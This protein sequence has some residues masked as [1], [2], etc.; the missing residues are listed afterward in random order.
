RS[1]R[2]T[3]LSRS[4]MVFTSPPPATTNLEGNLMNIHVSADT[5]AAARLGDPDATD[6]ILD[7]MESFIVKTARS[8][9]DRTGGDFDELAQ[10]ARIAVWELI[11]R[12][13]GDAAEFVA[14]AVRRVMWSYQ[15]TH[16]EAF[17]HGGVKAHA[18]Y[19]V[20]AQLDRADGDFALA[21]RYATIVPDARHRLS[22]ETAEAAVAALTMRSTD[23]YT[24][25][26]GAAT[27]EAVDTPDGKKCAAVRAIV[28]SLGPKQKSAIQYTYGIGAPEYGTQRDDELAEMLDTTKGSVQVARSRGERSFAKRYVAYVRADDPALADELKAAA[29]N[30][31]GTRL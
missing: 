23:N 7:A 2:L 26:P 21:A 16:A 31:L 14:Y 11:H 29:E 30:S 3:T 4:A 24:P 12:W 9:A 15:Q 19:A 13:D 10:G 6:R 8:H 17:A 27:A 5:L 28:D 20:L 22:R 25:L 1:R 18:I